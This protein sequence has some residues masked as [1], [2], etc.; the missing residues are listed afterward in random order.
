MA[1]SASNT[2]GSWDNAKKY[3]E[4]GL[5]TL[6][7]REKIK[8]NPEGSECIEIECLLRPGK[9]SEVHCAAVIG[10]TV[11]DPLKDTS[12]PSLNILIKLSAIISLVFAQVFDLGLLAKYMNED[13]KTLCAKGKWYHLQLTKHK[14]MV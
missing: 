6:K 11:G 2:G 14:W 4:A 8:I 9:G 13:T 10:D 1:I 7:K 3:V 5:L 12:G